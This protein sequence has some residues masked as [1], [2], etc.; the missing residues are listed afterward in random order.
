MVPTAHCIAKSG[1]GGALV[2]WSLAK[3]NS[4]GVV[5]RKNTMGLFGGA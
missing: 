2:V 3:A 5:A 1:G 4:R